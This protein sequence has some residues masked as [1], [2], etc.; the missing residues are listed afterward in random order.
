M[1]RVPAEALAPG[2]GRG[3][4]VP[5][6]CANSFL[7]RDTSEFDAPLAATWWAAYRQHFLTPLGPSVGFREWPRGVERRADVDSGPIVF[8]IGAAAS[9]LGISAAKSQGDDALA[10]QLEASREAAL[11]ALASEKQTRGVLPQVSAFEGRR[12]RAPSRDV[13]NMH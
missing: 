4:K 9:A 6:G 12:H 7:V 13:E 8:G 5:R 1:S 10:A 2:V 3:A 11:R